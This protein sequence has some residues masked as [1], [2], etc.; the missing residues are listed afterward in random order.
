MPRRSG[1]EVMGLMAF[2]Y[3]LAPTDDSLKTR[4]AGPSSSQPFLYCPQSIM[5]VAKSQMFFSQST[6]FYN[7]HKT[8]FCSDVKNSKTA[9]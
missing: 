1:S 7:P 9:C 6:N 2:G 8:L 3:R 4:L 5:S